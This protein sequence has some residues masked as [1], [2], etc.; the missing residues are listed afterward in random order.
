MREEGRGGM[1]EEK[2]GMREEG[3]EGGGRMREE[4]KRE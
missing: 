3:N 4:G 2:V 1:K